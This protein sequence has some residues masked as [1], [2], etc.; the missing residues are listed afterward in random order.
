VVR[1]KFARCISS[2]V[3]TWGLV[4][5][6]ARASRPGV[7]TARPRTILR[8][9][10]K[11]PLG[12]IATFIE[13]KGFGFIAPDDGGSDLFVHIVAVTN[14]HTLQRDQRVSFDIG[15]DERRGKPRAKKVRV[16]DGAAR[17]ADRLDAVAIDND[18]LLTDCSQR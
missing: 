9:E 3:E 13:K 12:T 4:M 18:F 11:M 8:S 7:I 15:T 17:T 2:P 14:S 10:N 16:I 5:A 1:A 6:S